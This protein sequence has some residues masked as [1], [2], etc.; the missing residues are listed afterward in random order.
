MAE[1]YILAIDQSTSGTKALLFD[2]RGK[3]VCRSDMG[4]EQKISAN[5][6]VAHDPQEIYRNTLGT[7]KDVIKKAGID[8]GSIL[9]ASI[10]NQR[11][12]ASCG[13]GRAVFRSMMP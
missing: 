4:H 7:V 2:S 8:S 13:T 12:T 1:S 10:S 5:G 3:M 9:G 6:W 11:E